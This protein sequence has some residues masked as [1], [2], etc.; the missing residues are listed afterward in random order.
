MSWPPCCLAN[1]GE[2]LALRVLFCM[3]SMLVLIAILSALALLSRVCGGT[4][5]MFLNI[6]IS[7]SK[8]REVAQAL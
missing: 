6:G 4:G 3:F 8:T 1:S 2:H 7:S 5:D